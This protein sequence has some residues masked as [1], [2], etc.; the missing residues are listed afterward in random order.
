MVTV[1]L[2]VVIFLA[3]VEVL[4]INLTTVWYVISAIVSLVLAYLNVLPY[5]QFIVFV[6]L[7]TLLLIITK[8]L[9][10]KFL[11]T[12]NTRTNLDRIIGMTG[13]V[14]E[15]IDQNVVGEVKVDGKLWSA[16]A[17]KKIEKG[18]IVRVLQINSTKII[19]EQVTD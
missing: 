9:I 4:T 5:V 2:L 16:C 19:V 1:W 6:I 11:K 13:I 10:N 15:K 8:P 12:K 7:G 3:I 14:T 17:D 18:T